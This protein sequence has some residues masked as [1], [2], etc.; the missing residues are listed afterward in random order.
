MS[1][2]FTT[3]NVHDNKMALVLLR[4]IQNRNVLFSV[5]DTAYDSQ[6]I[7]EIAGTCDIFAV[8]PIN[9]RNGQRI[10]STHRRVL[11]YFAQ[12]IFGKQLT[13]ERGE[14][15]QQFSNLKDKGL[16]QPRWYGQ[17]RYLLHIQLVFLIQ[18]SQK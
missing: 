6:H 3:A 2:A 1:Y 11:S 15:Q 12:T 9:P 13:K 16:K 18:N 14:I 4:D 10:K 5:A 7:Y 8:N 17:N